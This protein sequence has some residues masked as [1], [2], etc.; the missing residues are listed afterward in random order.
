MPSLEK[1]DLRW[2]AGHFPSRFAAEAR[3]ANTFLFAGYRS[4]E[5]HPATRPPNTVAVAA[6]TRL[7]P[8]LVEQGVPSRPTS[9]GV[10]ESTDS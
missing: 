2:N 3:R 6:V 7:F 9:G 4:R 8:L 5:D 10:E 1:L